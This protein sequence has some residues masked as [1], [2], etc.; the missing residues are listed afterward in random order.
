M[1]IKLT[2]E[3]WDNKFTRTTEEML[4]DVP[5]GIKSEYV[6]TVTDA[7][8][9]TCIN[10]GYAL[11]NRIGYWVTKE[12]HDFNYYVEDDYDAELE[13]DSENT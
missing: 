1:F 4:N 11:V 6:W 9:C 13:E 7:D 2:D 8:N 12:P 3:E 5:E 10:A